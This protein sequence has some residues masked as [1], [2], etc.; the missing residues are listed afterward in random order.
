MSA[1]LTRGRVLMAGTLLAAAALSACGWA[2]SHRANEGHALEAGG[3]MNVRYGLLDGRVGEVDGFMFPP[4]FN[5]GRKPVTLLAV[6]L[7]HVPEGADIL[8]YRLLNYHETGNEYLTSSRIGGLPKDG[9]YSSYRNFPLTKHIVLAPGKQSPWYAV[10]YVRVNRL[11]VR[12]I[13][14]CVY[15]YVVGGHR[16]SQELPCSF[17]VFSRTHAKGRKGA[18]KRAAGHR[19]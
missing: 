15:D 19:R 14:G 3:P 9:E 17:G 7:K 6:H 4:M 12:W 11:P 13:S 18:E 16:Y 8:R 5:S 2:W 1:W 10:F